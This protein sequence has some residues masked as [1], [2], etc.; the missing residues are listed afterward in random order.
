MSAFYNDHLLLGSVTKEDQVRD[1]PGPLY[2]WGAVSLVHIN[3]FPPFPPT[4]AV[5]F[6]SVMSTDDIRW[7][8]AFDVA[9][10]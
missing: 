4:F 10:T 8:R 3:F 7:K 9:W 6:H 2:V 1:G 5:T